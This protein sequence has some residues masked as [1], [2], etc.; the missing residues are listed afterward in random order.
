MK[1]IMI[2]MAMIFALSGASFGA[3]A[4]DDPCK[5]LA[6]GGG[7]GGGGGGGMPSVL[8][9]GDGPK[10]ELAS[11]EAYWLVGKFKGETA[12]VNYFEVDLDSQ[13]WLAT[14]YRTSVPYYAVD[15]GEFNAP[16]VGQRVKVAVRAQIRVAPKKNTKTYGYDIVLKLLADPT[17]V[18]EKNRPLPRSGVNH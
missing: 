18:D 13:P 11:G 5:A 10:L 9:S 15:L 8:C 16:K 4:S 2:L 7:N 1:K 17:K 3:G 6:G 14:K 12:G